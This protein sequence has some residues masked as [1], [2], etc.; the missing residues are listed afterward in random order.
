MCHKAIYS[1]T[2]DAVNYGIFALISKYDIKSRTVLYGL[3]FHKAIYSIICEIVLYNIIGK[4][5]IIG[6]T[7]W[8]SI[9]DNTC[10]TDI[11]DSNIFRNNK[12][13]TPSTIGN[14][15]CYIASIS[16]FT[17]SICKLQTTLGNII[18]LMSYSFSKS[19]LYTL[20]ISD[21]INIYLTLV[22]IDQ[23]I[24]HTSAKI[25][26]INKWYL[27]IYSLG[28][29]TLKYSGIYICTYILYYIIEINISL[30]YTYIFSVLNHMHFSYK[31]K[32][33]PIKIGLY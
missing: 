25:K 20:F 19:N 10:Q 4:T 29:T 14:I 15:I 1:I 8:A 18:W 24:F 33:L 11:L 23:T 2:C 9:F 31:D 7:F 5:V 22:P 30:D 17:N 13:F 12:G 28:N 21:Y 32:I 27:L 6:N 3:M 26:D 16:I